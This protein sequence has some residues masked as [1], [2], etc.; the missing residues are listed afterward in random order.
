MRRAAASPLRLMDIFRPQPACPPPP[1]Y[2]FY[3][4]RV[5]RHWN[6]R[7]MVEAKESGKTR[8]ALPPRRA[9]PLADLHVIRNE[10][11][12]IRVEYCFNDI[13]HR[14]TAIRFTKR[15]I[16]KISRPRPSSI[17]LSQ[18]RALGSAGAFDERDGMMVQVYHRRGTV[19]DSRPNVEILDQSNVPSPSGNRSTMIVRC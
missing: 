12:L 17:R 15:I 3:S 11:T 7:V 19:P 14:D 9:N 4:R 2:P 16:I 10:R 6:I 5:P 13:T 18:F 8:R 1:S